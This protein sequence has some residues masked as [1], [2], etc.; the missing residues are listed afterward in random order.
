MLTPVPF[1]DLDS[2]VISQDVMIDVMG[3]DFIHFQVDSTEI[4]LVEQPNHGVASIVNDSI[5]YEP[6]AGFSGYDTLSYQLCN[7][8]FNG[9]CNTA[10]CIIKV[11]LVEIFAFDDNVSIIMNETSILF[12]L[13]NDYGTADDEFILSIIEHGQHGAAQVLNDTSFIYVPDDEF[14][15][16]DTMKYQICYSSLPELCDVAYI[17]IIIEAI[18]PVV[19][20]DTV[21]TDMNQAVSVNVLD[22]D[23]NEAEFELVVLI[24]ED[25][26]HGVSEVNDSVITYTPDTDYWGL[27]TVHYRISKA[28]DAE[29]YDV[30]Y[31]VINVVFVE[32][33]NEIGNIKAV[34]IFPNPNNGFFK[35]ELI[36]NSPQE[37]EIQ[38]SDVNGKIVYVTTRKV[39]TGV[40]HIPI[41]I[42]SV[43]KGIYL[44]N[45]IT[46]EGSVQQK[47]VIK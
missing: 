17:Y 44:L 19:I 45:I 35:M 40:N 31:L 16:L 43:K 26:A 22:N 42:V 30:G 36:M 13:T 1:D 38:L 18:L 20:M 21:T 6:E 9:Y 28:D 4:E 8:G 11:Q 25:A 2:T 46:K 27:D 5:L 23:I 33:V 3:N 47:L 41:Q 39:N 29:V 15:G 34:K 24:E 12:P 7:S 10:L 32:S 14:Y 37:I